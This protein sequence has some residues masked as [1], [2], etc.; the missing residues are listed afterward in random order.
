MLFAPSTE[1]LHNQIVDGTELAAPYFFLDQPF[2]IGFQL[3]R[4][5][6]NLASLE[7]LRKLGLSGVEKV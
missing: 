6:F 5:T 3:H 4:H 7:P 2:G 1:A